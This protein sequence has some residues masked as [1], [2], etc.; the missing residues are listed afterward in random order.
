MSPALAP[1]VALAPSLTLA[2][3]VVL[4]RACRLGPSAQSVIT[5]DLSQVDLPFHQK[6]GLQQSIHLL[7]GLDGVGV[8]Y[9]QPE[10]VVR[11]RLV[12]EII[13]AYERADAERLRR[14]QEQGSRAAEKP[15][16]AAEEE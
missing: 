4:D 10:D 12:K 14:R 6:S 3:E 16:K 5:G 13:R 7:E 9:L 2:L 11:H 1:S 15:G 8:V